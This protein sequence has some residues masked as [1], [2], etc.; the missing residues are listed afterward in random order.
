[1]FIISKRNFRVRRADGSPY[2]VK[3]DFV[4]DIPEEV[5]GSRLIQGAMKTGLVIAA[6]STKDRAVINADEAAQEKQDSVDIRPDAKA[7]KKARQ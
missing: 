5:F 6:R 1:M 7:A 4:G 2:L 3:K